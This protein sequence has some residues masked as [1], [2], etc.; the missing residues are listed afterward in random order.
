MNDANCAFV[1]IYVHK[2]AFIEVRL[3]N[4]HCLTLQ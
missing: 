1:V 3:F 4:L 2:K